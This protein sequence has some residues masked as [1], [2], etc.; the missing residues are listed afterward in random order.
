MREKMQKLL[1][2]LKERKAKVQDAIGA[3]RITNPGHALC[4]ERERLIGKLELL[5]LLMAQLDEM[6]AKP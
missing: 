6:E 1:D 4:K 5:S 2:G 3:E